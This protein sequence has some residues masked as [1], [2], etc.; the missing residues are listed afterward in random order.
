VQQIIYQEHDIKT[1]KK[2]LNLI[3]FISYVTAAS[4]K[5][6]V[7]YIIVIKENQSVNIKDIVNKK[8]S[9]CQTI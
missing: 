3:V 2:L 9:F 1:V 4:R 6:I 8:N 7:R 5:N